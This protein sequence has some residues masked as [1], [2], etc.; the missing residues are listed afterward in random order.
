MMGSSTL[1]PD[2]LQQ[3][4]VK[5]KKKHDKVCKTKCVIQAGIKKKKENKKKV[6]TVLQNISEKVQRKNE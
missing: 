4:R 1:P 5:V 3:A 6:E 2:P